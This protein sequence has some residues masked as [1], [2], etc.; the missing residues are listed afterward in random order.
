MAF[1]AVGSQQGLHLRQEICRGACRLGTGGKA[2]DGSK[3]RH[4]L[5]DVTGGSP[6]A[7]SKV[8]IVVQEYLDGAQ[9]DSLLEAVA[10]HTT[11]SFF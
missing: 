8:G 7:H 5:G 10:R 9:D 1:Y 3:C 6:F 11:I 2:S 4:L